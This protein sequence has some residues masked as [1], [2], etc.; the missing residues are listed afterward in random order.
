M[1]LDEIKALNAL[2]QGIDF[3]VKTMSKQRAQGR[4]FTD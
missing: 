4:Y 1:A 3:I 2:I